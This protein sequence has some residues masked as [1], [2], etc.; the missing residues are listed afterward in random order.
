LLTFVHLQHAALDVCAV[1]ELVTK[2]SVDLH[3]QLPVLLLA[4]TAVVMH[5]LLVMYSQG[6]LLMSAA[7]YR[8]T[9]L[10]GHHCPQVLLLLVSLA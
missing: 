1:C 7:G 6:R 8:T 5:G 10:A 4:D 9:W 3:G 2:S